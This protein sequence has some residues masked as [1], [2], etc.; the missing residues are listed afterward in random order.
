[1]K[2]SICT[3]LAAAL[4]NGLKNHRLCL[5]ENEVSRIV[6]EKTSSGAIMEFGRQPKTK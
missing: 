2:S 3:I 6:P 4:I 5:C 1:M